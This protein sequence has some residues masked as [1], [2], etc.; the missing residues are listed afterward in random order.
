M[1]CQS[2]FSTVSLCVF[3]A[4]SV[5]S[6]ILGV[7][8]SRHER[9]SPT[10]LIVCLTKAGLNPVTPS[11][12]S[13]QNDSL[14]V[15]TRLIYQPASLVYANTAEDVGAAVKCGAVHDVKVNARSGGHSYASFGT[16][17]E[18]GHLIISL[19]NLN[20]MKLSGEYVTVGAG[21]KLGPLY[22]FL[23]ENG[24]RAAVFGTAP[25][26]GVGGHL[27]GGYGFLSRKWGLFLDQVVEMEVVKADGSVV[28]ANKDSNADLFWALRG[29]PPSFGVITQL[30]IL[31]HPAPT[32]AA[33]FAF[34]YNWSTPDVASSA[35][36]IF[37]HWTAEVDMPSDLTLQVQYTDASP[38]PTFWLIGA[39]YGD[40]GIA[41]LNKTV[42][43]LW[44]ALLALN[45]SVPTATIFEDLNWIQ[46]VLY[47]AGLDPTTDPKVALEDAPAIHYPFYCNSV[48]Y[49][50][51]D[52]LTNA[53][54]LSFA[55]Y[56]YNGTSADM[57]WIAYLYLFGGKNSAISAVPQDAT[58]YNARDMF[59]NLQVCGN[60]NTVPFP[61]DGLS[62]TEGMLKSVTDMMP[63]VRF[64]GYPNH[65]D[66]QLS[67]EEAHASYYPTHTQRLQEIM[68][69]ENPKA[70]FDYPQG[71]LPV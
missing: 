15:N 37:Q 13:Y 55:Q 27:H 9:N 30:T 63:G 16:G 51:D 62:F 46:N 21:T 14:P 70:V 4:A 5:S 8:I 58:A 54:T 60:R 20:N 68:K 48:F 29:A 38:V 3:L 53:S 42:Q 44:D 40:D 10:A 23:W 49:S 25:Q 28:T 34:T 33:T 24:Q 57:N 11:N 22:H 66:S 36:Q 52:L 2:F 1:V 32:H 7:N 31:T 6:E 41:G 50:A 69:K 26:I 35:F 64:T 61:D 19:D 17:G 71:F 12:P 59:I 18:D 65:I 56:T 39:Y 67:R 47:E 45:D 43:P